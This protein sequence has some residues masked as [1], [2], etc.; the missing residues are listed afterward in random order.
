[1]ISFHFGSI[2]N[3]TK[4][5]TRLLTG[6]IFSCSIWRH[7]VVQL[8]NGLDFVFLSAAVWLCTIENHSLK[9]R[10]KSIW[11]KKK[12]HHNIYLQPFYWTLKA[13]RI[14]YNIIFF[15]FKLLF[16]CL[17]V[18]VCFCCC[19]FCYE[20]DEIISWIPSVKQRPL[21]RMKRN[22]LGILSSLTFK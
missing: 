13:A 15:F 4:R 9:Q 21:K 19:F 5:S 20:D 7:T 2:L 18:F 3:V 14:V 1:M 12:L 11:T 8:I 22:I 10:K 6:S 16:F 17:F